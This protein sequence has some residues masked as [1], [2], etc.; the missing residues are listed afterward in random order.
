MNLLDPF[1]GSGTTGIVCSILNRKFIG[2]DSYKEYLDVAIK[3][4]KDK[5]KVICYFLPKLK[6]I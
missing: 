4:F 2:F 3:R 5:K 1:M 6:I